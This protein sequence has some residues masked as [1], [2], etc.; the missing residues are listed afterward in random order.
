MSEFNFEDEEIEEGFYDLDDEDDEEVDESPYFGEDEDFNW[1]SDDDEDFYNPDDEDLS[2]M[3]NDEGYEEESDDDDEDFFSDSKLSGIFSKDANEDAEDEDNEDV[4]L[5]DGS[6]DFRDTKDA[7]SDTGIGRFI[8]APQSGDGLRAEDYR[9]VKE[10][11]DP[12]VSLARAIEIDKGSFSL[13]MGTISI[14]D[15]V[16]PTMVKDSRRETYLGLTRSVEELGVL[17]PVHV[18]TIYLNRY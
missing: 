1:G 11:K 7:D 18:M 12:D 4:V 15:L 13:K 2:T 5:F 6:D 10:S 16:I 3:S 14:S 8:P 17:V 9:V